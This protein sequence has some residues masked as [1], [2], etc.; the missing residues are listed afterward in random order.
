MW[1]CLFLSLPSVFAL[2]SFRAFFSAYVL[3]FLCLLGE[4][5]LVSLCNVC[6]CLCCSDWVISIVLSSS[7]PIISSV[8][9]SADESIH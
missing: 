9:H 2:H 5:T 3:G 7:S 6:F 1:I 8:P 4:F